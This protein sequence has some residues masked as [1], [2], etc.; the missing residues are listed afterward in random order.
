M[1]LY[2]TKGGGTFEGW[3]LFGEGR[4]QHIYIH[5]DLYLT[6]YITFEYF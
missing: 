5:V 2:A 4:L 6:F 1:T 3:A